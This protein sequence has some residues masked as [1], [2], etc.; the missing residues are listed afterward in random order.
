MYKIEFHPIISSAVIFEREY[1]TLP[2]AVAALSA[3]GEYTLLLHAH[4]FMPDYSNMAVL[5][6]WKYE[7]WIEINDE[8]EEL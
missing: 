3:I 2:E 8:G 1:T 5:L 4:H 7:E 6:Q